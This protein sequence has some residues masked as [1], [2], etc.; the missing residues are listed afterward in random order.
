VST[1]GQDSL[2]DAAAPAERAGFRL[3][4]LELYNWGTFHERVW[5]LECRGENTLVTGDI[6]SG[7]STLVD[8]L[9]TLLV[10]P[11]KTAYNRA[12]GAEARERTARSYLLGVYKSERGDA[13]LAARQVSLRD[14]RAY[15]VL[16]AQFH[17]EGFAQTVTLAQVFWLADAKAQPN[18]LYVVADAPLEIARHFADFGADVGA[19]RKRLRGLR[20]VESFESF[21]PYAAA[22]RRRFG[23]ENEQAFDLFHQTVSMKS[24]GD[25]TDFVREHML[26]PF[27]VEPRIEALLHHFDDLNRAHESVLRAKDQISRLAPLV[28]NCHR[29]TTLLV[30]S[31]RLRN[32]REALRPYF[33]LR[34][35]EL[36]D[37]RLG[38]LDAEIGRLTDRLAAIESE[39]QRRD[40]ERD[41]LRSAISAQGGDR[42]ER[43]RQEITRLEVL[44]RERSVRAERYEALAESLGLKS[45][46]DD[47]DF[48]DNRDH[49]EAEAE[50]VES[51]MA[52]VQNEVTEA[53]VD[54]RGVREQ[55]GLLQ[56]ELESLR[57]RRSNIPSRMLELRRSLCRAVGARSE[58]ELPFAGEVLSVREEEAALW[59]GAIE[60][61]MHGFGLSLLVTDAHYGS[62]AEWVDKTPLGDRLVY[63]RIRPGRAGSSPGGDAGPDALW[64]KVSIKPDTP[65]Y[66]W[67][68]AELARRFDHVCCDDLGRFRRERKAVTRTGQV[69]GGEE[70]HEKDDR[71]RLDD[72]TRYVLGW[73]NQAKIDALARQV[74]DLERR[75]QTLGD[76]IAAADDHR[77]RLQLRKSQLAQFA[78]FD[79]HREL[80]WRSVAVEI[81]AKS[82]EL[83]A[84]ETTSDVLRTLRSRLAEVERDL[85]EGRES[86]ATLQTDLGTPSRSALRPPEP[87]PTARSSSPPRRLRWSPRSFQPS[88]PCATRPVNRPSRSRPVTIESANCVTPSSGASTPRNDASR[89]SVTRSSP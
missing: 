6:G 73:T 27:E 80:D 54:L 76:R 88:T 77:R 4:R 87:G 82:D 24:V 39:T 53:N 43:L 15:S 83:R 23:V 51:E 36:L 20:N 75:A 56:A 81:Q 45:A 2:F 78:T 34:K 70:R 28:D 7:K 62:V 64:R 38:N 10:P 9:T 18:R 79:S 65:H 49:A 21:P 33:A 41:E 17:N 8:A 25:L 57:G 69:K 59:E 47:E 13:G 52:R 89:P 1:S 22:F 86:A 58:D 3:Q 16:L 60:R 26:Q 11:Q 71:H 14:A 35:Q 12:A 61:L 42:M 63:F 50:R 72:R 32:A 5:S 19:L 67:L 48:T 30:E 46:P 85:R 29:H 68:E 37:R 44:R 40:L 31:H 55:H 84:L 74:A 66:P